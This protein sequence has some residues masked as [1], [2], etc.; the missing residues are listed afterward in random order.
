[1]AKQLG[2]ATLALEKD[3]FSLEPSLKYNVQTQ[4]AQPILAISQKKGADT[5][6]AAYDIEGE[7]GILEWIR[8][9]YKVCISSCLPFAYCLLLSFVHAGCC[10]ITLSQRHVTNDAHEPTQYTLC[11]VRSLLDVAAGQI[12]GHRESS[13]RLCTCFGCLR[14]IVVSLNTTMQKFR[15]FAATVGS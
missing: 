14:C 1:M 11:G 2:I 8:K 15:A 4:H 7:T 3:G 6:K 9:P 10:I 5:L 13:G 12:V